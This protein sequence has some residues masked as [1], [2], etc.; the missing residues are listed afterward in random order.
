MDYVREI[1][2]RVALD[3]WTTIAHNWPFLLASVVVASV[4]QVFVGTD[5]LARWL[6]ARTW[7]AVLGAVV[8]GALT[9]FCSCGTTA[10]VQPP[11]AA[12]N[13]RATQA[14]R[15]RG[16]GEELMGKIRPQTENPGK[17]KAAWKNRSGGQTLE[18]GSTSG[19]G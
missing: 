10:V 13:I 14:R 18:A 19:T 17:G 3:V 8:L 12:A 4:I 11:K 16:S 1:F 6:R 2:S 7:I 9:P 15:R 5:R